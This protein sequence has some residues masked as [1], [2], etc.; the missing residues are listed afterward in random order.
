[1]SSAFT[2]NIP[3][4]FALSVS[5]YYLQVL[6][7]LI[8]V[9]D[10]IIR[11]L[12]FSYIASIRHYRSSIA[13]AD[14]NSLSCILPAT[15]INT[16]NKEL[17]SIEEII[18]IFLKNDKEIINTLLN[19]NGTIR[20]KSYY[21]MIAYTN[22]YCNLMLNMNSD[23]NIDNIYKT[24]ICLQCGEIYHYDNEISDECQF[25]YAGANQIV[26]FNEIL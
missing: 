2:A 11:S 22:H 26:T 13:M 23:F 10:N 7:D 1:M 21:S 3:F 24:Y 18:E 6:S 15:F 5:A 20:N 4:P 9:N 14:K 12:K 16:I 17:L 25:C 8:S 19:D